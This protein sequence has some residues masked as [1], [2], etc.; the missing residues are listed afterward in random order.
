MP[1]KPLEWTGLAI[2]AFVRNSLPATQ[3]QRWPT[4]ST[5]RITLPLSGRQE[6]FPIE[7]DSTAA[8]PLQGLVRRCCQATAKTALAATRKL[9]QP[10]EQLSPSGQP[11][12]GAPS[13][14]P[15]AVEMSVQA[16]QDVETMQRLVAAGWGRRRIARELGCSPETVRRYLGQSSWQHYGKPCCNSVLDGQRE[17]LRQRLLAHRGNA[18]VVRAELAR[19]K[20]DCRICSIRP[21]FADP[22]PQFSTCIDAS[23]AS[24]FVQ[25]FLLTVWWKTLFGQSVDQACRSHSLG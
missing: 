13:L 18:D 23:I 22:R 19:E 10:V 4:A 7:S 1:N 16:A 20:N 25:G 6:A 24:A 17:W 14:E 3:G 2:Q 11:P 12:A 21:D 15:M 8:C 5:D 9:A